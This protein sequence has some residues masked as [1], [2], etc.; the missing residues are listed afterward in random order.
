MLVVTPD[1]PWAIGRIPD[2]P[3][4]RSV[5]P[6]PPPPPPPP[7][8]EIQVVPFDVNTLFVFPGATVSKAPAPLPS[9]TSFPP[10]LSTPVPPFVT[11]RIPDKS[12]AVVV[13]GSPIGPVGPVAPVMPVNP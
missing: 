2:A 11:G 13:P 8:A 4:V 9:K 3:V 7:G 10:K 12:D 5:M 1:P 6:P